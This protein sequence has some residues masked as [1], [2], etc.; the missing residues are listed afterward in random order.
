MGN[1]VV[2]EAVKAE[3]QRCVQAA[4]AAYVPHY[5]AQCT[6][7]SIVEKIDPEAVGQ[8]DDIGRQWDQATTITVLV[9]SVPRVPHRISDVPLNSQLGLCGVDTEMALALSGVIDQPAE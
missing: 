1:D 6:V 5:M 7:R 2:V 4:L 3:R 9:S 8:V